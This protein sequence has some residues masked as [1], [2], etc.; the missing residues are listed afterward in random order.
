MALVLDLQNP[1]NWN[2]IY[3]SGLLQV[4]RTGSGWIPIPAFEPP[5]LCQHRILFCT[6]ES[7]RAKQFWWLGVR[8]EMLID[9]PGTPFETIP[10][11]KI[12]IPVNRG[13][14][15]IF[16]PLADQFRLRIEIPPWHEEMKIRIWEY[17]GTTADSTE[18]LLITAAQGIE[19]DL[20]RI[21]GKID[22]L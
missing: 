16:P 3:E 14:L 7:Q 8:L 12:N 21:E 10:A 18:D 19:A 2:A 22:Q 5:I 15:S 6:A 13:F 9:V 11:Y 1:L 17:T 20:L 4:S